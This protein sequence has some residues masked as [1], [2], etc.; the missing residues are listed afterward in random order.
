MSRVAAVDAQ[1]SL[2]AAAG[3]AAGVGISKLFDYLKLRRREA[4]GDRRQTEAGWGKLIDRLEKRLDKSDKRVDE[5]E[6]RHDECQ[7]TVVNLTRALNET[8]EQVGMPPVQTH[9]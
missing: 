9:D 5:C 8:R 2:I 6:A 4:S 1:S 3:T 7:R